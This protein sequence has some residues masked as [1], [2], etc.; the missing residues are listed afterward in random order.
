M[1][2]DDPRPDDAEPE[3]FE[4]DP[5][6]SDGEAPQA[7]GVFTEQTSPDVRLDP[8]HPAFDRVQDG[9][10]IDDAYPA[11]YNRRYVKEHGDHLG[12]EPTEGPK[13]DH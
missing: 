1:S 11:E 12:N 5:E 13:S 7:M 2:A 6:V 10:A 4:D 8:N 9:K 3:T